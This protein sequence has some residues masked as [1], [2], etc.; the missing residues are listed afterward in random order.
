MVKFSTK[1]GPGYKK[2][3]NSIETLLEGLCDDLPKQSACRFVQHPLQKLNYPRKVKSESVGL[4]EVAWSNSQRLYLSHNL[5]HPATQ[6]VRRETLFGEGSWVVEA[7]YHESLHPFACSESNTAW[8]CDNWEAR[9]PEFRPWGGCWKLCLTFW[10]VRYFVLYLHWRYCNIHVF[11]VLRYLRVHWL[12]LHQQRKCPIFAR[13]DNTPHWMPGLMECWL[14]V[15][16]QICFIRYLGGRC[17]AINWDWWLL[18]AEESLEEPG[19]WR[20]K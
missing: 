15:L 19:S 13:R 10:K 1:D 11:A 3:L 18:Y 4:E 12:V 8:Y 16:R 17:V 14:K 20:C 7:V 5:L 6:I 9:S 2:V